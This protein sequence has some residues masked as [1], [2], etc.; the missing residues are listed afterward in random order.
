MRMNEQ[1]N[2]RAAAPRYSTAHVDPETEARRLVSA[3]SNL[4]LRLSFTY[5]K[6]THDAQ[7]ICQGVLM[8]LVGRSESFQSTEHEKAW[9][10]RTT[11]NACKDALRNAYRL[12]RTRRLAN[13]RRRRTRAAIQEALEARSRSKPRRRA[14]GG[15]RRSYRCNRNVNYRER[16]GRRRV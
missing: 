6:S 16:P 10:I 9:V 3:Y 5:L 7:D 4:I 11:A 15:Q 8:K 2:A 14:F 13:A 1:R 12:L